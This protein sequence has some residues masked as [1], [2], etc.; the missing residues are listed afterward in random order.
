MR[1]GTDFEI[2]ATNY[3]ISTS[4]ERGNYMF[5]GFRDSSRNLP[6]RTVLLE[7]GFPVRGAIPLSHRLSVL[8]VNGKK[9]AI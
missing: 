5:L 3:I 6:V 9:P 1:A 4:G 7:A 8:L 2:N